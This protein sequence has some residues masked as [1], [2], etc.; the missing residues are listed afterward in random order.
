MSSEVNALYKDIDEIRRN[1][2]LIHYTCSMCILILT[3]LATVPMIFASIAIIDNHEYGSIMVGLIMGIY[4]TGIIINI[5]VWK[6]YIDKYNLEAHTIQEKIN[7]IN[8]NDIRAKKAIMNI[9]YATYNPH[10]AIN[11]K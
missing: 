1:K 6:K 3:L 8:A 4:V 2:N 5:I 7:G 11:V 10:I 9:G